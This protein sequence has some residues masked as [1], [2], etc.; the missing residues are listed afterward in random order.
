ME[1]PAL[2]RKCRPLELF[3]DGDRKDHSYNVY[4]SSST[5]TVIICDSLFVE[6]DDKNVEDLIDEDRLK[7]NVRFPP[8]HFDTTESMKI[9]NVTTY[10]CKKSR[11][12][13]IESQDDINKNIV[14]NYHN[15]YI[16]SD[17]IESDNPTYTKDVIT[18][19]ISLDENIS[20]HKEN[21]IFTPLKNRSKDISSSQSDSQNSQQF[22]QN[23]PQFNSIMGT[24]FMC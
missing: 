18:S 21:I 8:Q 14:N 5:K 7:K 11:C 23:S 22:S 1:T 2:V 12:D 9:G 6:N 20:C 3:K 19:K 10:D 13:S 15:T 24:D 4:L 16:R 17:T